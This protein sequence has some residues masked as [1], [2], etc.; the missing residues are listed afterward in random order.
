MF[1]AP[2]TAVFGAYLLPFR[3]VVG[4]AK[5]AVGKDAATLAREQAEVARKRVLPEGR[6]TR[7][8][9]QLRTSD[10]RLAD[11]RLGAETGT[12]DVPGPPVTVTG[13]VGPDGGVTFTGG[14]AAGAADGTGQ[15][16][17]GKHRAERRTAGRRARRRRPTRAGSAPAGEG[18]EG[19]A[20]G[21]RADRR[22]RARRRYSCSPTSAR[23]CCRGR[24]SRCGRPDDRFGEGDDPPGEDRSQGRPD[25]PAQRHDTGRGDARSPRNCPSTA[26]RRGSCPSSKPLA[27]PCCTRPRRSS[28]CWWEPDI[29]LTGRGHV[30]GGNVRTSPGYR[31][32]AMPSTRTLQSNIR[33]SLDRVKVRIEIRRAVLED[34]R[35]QERTPARSPRSWSPGSGSWSCSTQTSCVRRTRTSSGPSRGTTSR[36][37]GSGRRPPPRPPS[38]QSSISSGPRLRR[39]G[40][41]WPC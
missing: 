21:R 23:G 41:G 37:A 34:L 15:R 19:G 36:R 3:A 26:G 4:T 35:Q 32:G 38:V 29:Y 31:I 20:E 16:S 33:H 1:N 14:D 7:P 27:P 39:P 24:P 8:S 9:V 11:P 30:A 40:S 2:Y 6:L 5:W 12:H 22:C 13:K 18:L 28:G 25:A 10:P 17:T